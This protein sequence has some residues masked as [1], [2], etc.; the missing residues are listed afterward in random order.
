MALT[1]TSFSM[2]DGAPINV[3]D[4]GAVGDGVTDNTA[5]FNALCDY[6]N[7][8]YYVENKTEPLAIY[9]PQGIFKYSDTLDFRAPVYLFSENAA[10]LSY[11]GGGNA[12]S[13]GKPGI[14][15]GDF[16]VY[17]QAAYT[18][19]GLRF[20]ST[21]AA[22]HGIYVRQFVIQ[23]RIYNCI[24]ED[25]SS[26]S[27]GSNYC[28]FFQAENWDII[29]DGCRMFTLNRMDANANFICVRGL[30]LDSVLDGGQ[31]RATISNCFMAAYNNIDLG[32][33][34]FVSGVKS[35]VLG[36]SFV[37]SSY[38]IVLTA[39]ASGT[40]IDTVYAEM[41]DNA[42]AYITAYSNSSGGNLFY[43]FNVTVQNAYVNFH[44]HNIPLVKVGDANFLYRNWTIQNV[45]FGDIVANQ[46]LIERNDLPGQIGNIATRFIQGFSPVTSDNGRRPQI[47][48]VLA[49]AEN[50]YDPGN[51]FGVEEVT[52]ATYTLQQTDSGK[53]KKLTGG[54]AAVT[55]PNSTGMPHVPVGSVIYLQNASGG[56]QT[57]VGGAGV[58]LS[59]TGTTTT[60]T[61]TISVNGLA[62]LI[63]IQ[64]NV[65]LVDGPNV[66]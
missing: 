28:I 63:N 45:L 7:N 38:G 41:A 60:G 58:T 48:A 65:W 16:E 23:P 17:T 29:V 33:F 31:S 15:Y 44:E 64:S 22:V 66:T 20:T 53:I 24:F 3:L 8:T 32:V 50:W 19:D 40:I 54:F 49:N 26:G 43:A 46:L 10:T 2:I 12:M 52:G 14:G 56:N 6:V 5:A 1:K 30:R 61:R 59:L 9:F 47:T 62:R 36:G 39:E 51:V 42:I 57:I 55:V 27:G 13:L 4:W 25:F 18:V 35:R 11:Q 21:N 37:N 34:A